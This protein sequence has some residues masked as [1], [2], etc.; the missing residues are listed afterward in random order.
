MSGSCNQPKINVCTKSAPLRMRLRCCQPVSLARWLASV[1]KICERIWA[2]CDTLSIALLQGLICLT[3]F[4]AYMMP[5]RVSFRQSFPD[6]CRFSS[7]FFLTFMP[8]SG[9]AAPLSLTSLNSGGGSGKSPSRMD[10]SGAQGQNS[11]ET[12]CAPLFGAV[13]EEAVLR[14]TGADVW[15]FDMLRRETG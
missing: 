7:L 5:C 3:S 14:T 2:T 15:Q 12:S 9:A 6:V 8:M 13:G 1:S 4:N 10:S 11:R